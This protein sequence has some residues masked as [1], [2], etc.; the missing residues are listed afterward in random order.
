MT[1]ASSRSWTVSVAV[2]PDTDGW[3]WVVLMMT[4]CGSVVGVSTSPPAHR[5]RT[6]AD[7]GVDPGIPGIRLDAPPRGAHP[8]V[9]R[10]PS[11]A[12][13]PRLEAPSDSA[14]TDIL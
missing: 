3:V 9:T 2:V 10:V 12:R 11:G 4:S 8:G 1:I 6:R 13:W 7:P 5:A 14:R